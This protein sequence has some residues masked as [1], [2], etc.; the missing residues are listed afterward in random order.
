[1]ACNDK[2]EQRLKHVKAVQC[3]AMKMQGFT[4][5]LYG[6]AEGRVACG[7]SLNGTYSA[8]GGG[9]ALPSSVCSSNSFITRCSCS[10]V[11]ISLP[12]LLGTG[13]GWSVFSCARAGDGVTGGTDAVPR[14]GGRRSAARTAPAAD[15]ATGC[16]CRCCKPSSLRCWSSKPSSLHFN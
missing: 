16:L 13:E 15:F 3:H 14:S 12:A 2:S 8:A 7:P 4:A 6:V 1:M 9:P 11:E 5:N 10:G